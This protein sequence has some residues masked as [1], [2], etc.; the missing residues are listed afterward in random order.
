MLENANPEAGCV[1]AIALSVVVPCYNESDNIHELHRRVTAVCRSAVGEN[2]ELVLVNDGS[3]D[4]TWSAL[5]ELTDRDPHVVAV[6]LARNYGHQIA[7]SAGLQICRGE[8]TLILDGDLQDPPELLPEMMVLMDRGHDVVYGQRKE[9]DGETWFKRAS[10]AAFY[11]YFN[12]LID[13]RIPVDTGDFRLMSRKALA[14]LNA[15]PEQFRFVRG[16]V[17]WIGLKQAPLPYK[18]AARFAGETKYPLRRMLRFAVDAITSFSVRPL[19]FASH[20]G[21]AFGFL[22]LISL[23]CILIFWLRGDVVPGWT[24][25]AALILIL[26][27]IQLTVLG[28]LGEYLGR[29]YIEAKRRPLFIIDEIATTSSL[30]TDADQMPAFLHSTPAPLSQHAKNSVHE[31]QERILRASNAGR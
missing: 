27:S 20:I 1:R 24:S 23:G 25:L 7:L 15:M 29:M 28:I 9:R 3:T 4:G 31:L 18:R 5:T 2:Y 30:F 13:V 22:G 11:R 14:H 16:M 21:I 8:R 19:R 26:G 12:R 10:A 17:A 6:Q